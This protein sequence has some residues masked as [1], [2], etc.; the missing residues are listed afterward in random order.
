MKV[1]I[2]KDYEEMSAVAGGIIEGQIRENPSSVLG[3]ATGSTPIG[4]YKYL[5]EQ[6]KNNKISFKDVK[7]VNLDEYLGLEPTHDQSYRYFMNTNL[8]DHIDINKDNTNVPS[9]ICS[10]FD[11]ECDRYEELI[12][13]LGGIDLQLLGIGNNGHIGFNEPD[14]FFEGRTHVTPLTESTI[15]AN[16]RFFA[17]RD[18]V[19]TKAISMGTGTIF[20]AKKI[21]LVASGESKAKTILDTV[22]GKITPSVPAS[23]LQLHNDVTLVIDEDAAALLK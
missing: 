12:Q 20:K 4:L 21:V 5:I 22:R 15:N 18:D 17:S 8:F 7:T 3:L 19:P 10:D 16:A 11:K 1:I 23:I 2:T 13:N 9:G 6:Y 14:S